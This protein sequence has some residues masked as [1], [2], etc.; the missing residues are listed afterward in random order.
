M[1]EPEQES[2]P[3]KPLF[4]QPPP[5]FWRTRLKLKRITRLRDLIIHKERWPSHIDLAQPLA[6]LFPGEKLD[7]NAYSTDQRIE[8]EIQQTRRMVWWD[9][10]WIGV[11]T[12]VIW[13]ERPVRGLEPERKE[14]D[15]VMD[16]FRLPRAENP[17]AAFVAVI[18]VLQQGIGLWKGRLRQSKF[19]L[20]NPVIWAAKA[21]RLPITV[22]ERAG[23]GANEKSQ[24]LL[25]GGYGKFMRI[26]MGLILSFLALILGVK[27]PWKEI[28]TAI[29]DTIFK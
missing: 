16:Y 29:I 28:V 11:P 15:V 1:P 22:M 2:G 26:A 8:Q 5:G 4:F 9:L 25:L 14:F 7:A 23:F 6:V 20:F 18:D 17:H 12:G 10:N 19:E 3:S 21:I 24:E 27:V 13:T